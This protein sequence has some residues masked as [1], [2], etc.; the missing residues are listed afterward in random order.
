MGKLIPI[1]LAIAGLAA[2]AGAGYVL[3][4]APEPAA[5]CTQQ[6]DGCPAEA[7]TQPTTEPKNPEAPA[8]MSSEFVK[9]N[10]QFVVPI[11]HHEKIDALVVLSL[12]LE[13]PDG[14][15]ETVYNREPKLRDAILQ[16]L[17]D[18]ANSG[19]FDGAFTENQKMDILRRALLE[20]AQKEMGDGNVSNVLITDIARQDM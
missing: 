6:S 5:D 19:G 18:H 2:G 11:V 15:R 10:N 3:R 16:V 20:T 13:V 14:E 8:D 4:P 7:E 17:F 12:S 1:F 9:L